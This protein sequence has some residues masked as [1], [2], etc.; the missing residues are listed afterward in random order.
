M[1][2]VGHLGDGLAPGRH[3]LGADG[4]LRRL[5]HIGGDGL[6]PADGLGGRRLPLRDRVGRVAAVSGWNRFQSFGAMPLIDAILRHFPL[7]MALLDRLVDGAVVLKLRGRSYRAA[8]A[9]SLASEKNGEER[10]K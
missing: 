6:L 3:E 9:R 5:S 2:A 7:A 1:V 8:R 10:S 4:H